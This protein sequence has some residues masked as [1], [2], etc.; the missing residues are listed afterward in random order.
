MFTNPEDTMSKIEAARNYSK[1]QGEFWRAKASRGLS[2][3]RYQRA[4]S[5]MRHA[6]CVREQINGRG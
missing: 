3:D 6:W 5:A 2:E 4:L 1:A